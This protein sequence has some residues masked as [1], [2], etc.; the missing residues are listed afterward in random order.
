MRIHLL[1]DPLRL[2]RNLIEVRF[3]QH[4]RLTVSAFLRPVAPVPQLA[5]GFPFRS[6]LDK[7]FEGGLRVGYDPKVGRE[8]AADLRRRTPWP[9][10][11]EKLR[12]EC[13]RSLLYLRRP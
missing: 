4:V 2:Q 7:H 9:K 13:N 6:H 1:V 8:D 12:K 10:S 11:P 3:A 5:C